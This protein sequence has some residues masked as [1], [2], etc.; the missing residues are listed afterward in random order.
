MLDILANPTNRERL[1]AHQAHNSQAS[2]AQ[3][4]IAK[5]ELERSNL[6]DIIQT[7]GMDADL[8]ARLRAVDASLQDARASLA[9]S[10]HFVILADL[11]TSD[12]PLAQLGDGLTVDVQRSVLREVIK[13]IVVRPATHPGRS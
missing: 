10:D 7:T 3:S 2:D 9:Q 8:A 12:E 6:R 4:Q 5:L 13:R 1:V 11:P